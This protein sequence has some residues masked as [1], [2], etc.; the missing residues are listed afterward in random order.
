VDPDSYRNV[1]AVDMII[2]TGTP[3]QEAAKDELKAR[4]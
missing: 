3:W 2:P 4:F 1:R